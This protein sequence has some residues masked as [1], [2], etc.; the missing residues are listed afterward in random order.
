VT[1]R[2]VVRLEALLSAAGFPRRVPRVVANRGP[3]DGGGNHVALEVR[4]NGR[5]ATWELQLNGAGFSGVDAEPVRE[6]LHLLGELAEAGGRP[7]FRVV[8]NRLVESRAP[9]VRGSLERH[10]EGRRRWLGRASRPAR[11]SRRE[12]TEGWG[13]VNEDVP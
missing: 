11:G 10:R 4:W 6:L 2:D 1:D 3:R 8:V 12:L 7:A 9:E 13:R 5:S